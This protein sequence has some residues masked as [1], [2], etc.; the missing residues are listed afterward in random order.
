M[1]NDR[2]K[3][4]EDFKKRIYQSVER[5]SKDSQYISLKHPDF[6]GQE[7]IFL[8]SGFSF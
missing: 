8:T 4:K 2:A 6:E 1:Q 5:S 7:M 3:F